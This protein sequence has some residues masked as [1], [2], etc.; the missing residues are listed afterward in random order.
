MGSQ[1]SWVVE[2]NIPMLNLIWGP[3]NPMCSGSNICKGSEVGRVPGRKERPEGWSGRGG[4][5][6]KAAR[7][8]L[9][10]EKTTGRMSGLSKDSRKPWRALTAWECHDQT[11]RKQ[12]LSGSG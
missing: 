12:D 11:E 6:D 1:K 7:W 2:Q 5:G 10:E 4:V 3:G 9:E 8:A